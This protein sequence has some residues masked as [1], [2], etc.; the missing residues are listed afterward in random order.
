MF[1]IISLKKKKNFSKPSI[2]IRI[3]N[4]ADSHTGT[5]T[6]EPIPGTIAGIFNI[7]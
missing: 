5:P 3:I 7:E 6:N 2:A 4:V 1:K